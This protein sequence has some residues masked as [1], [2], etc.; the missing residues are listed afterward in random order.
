MKTFVELHD[1]ATGRLIYI[2]VDEIKYFSGTKITIGVS[3]QRPG[4]TITVK[5]HEG[6]IMNAI[7]K[8]QERDID[9]MV[10]RAVEK[11]RPMHTPA[12]TQPPPS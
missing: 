11:H 6:S 3:T 8:A 2:N 7:E 1:A 10:G 4:A 5:E 12:Y 9:D